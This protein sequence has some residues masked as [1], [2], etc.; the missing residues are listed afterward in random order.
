VLILRKDE[1]SASCGRGPGRRCLVP[2]GP[3]W[4]PWVPASLAHPT[5]AEKSRGSR[6]LHYSRLSCYVASHGLFVFGG[7][8]FGAG[9]WDLI[10][11]WRSAR[12]RSPRD[13]IDHSI[14]PVWGGQSCMAHLLPSSVLWTATSLEALCLDHTHTLR[15]N[16]DRRAGHRAARVEASRSARPST[17]T[18][19]QRNFGAAFANLL[20]HRALLLRCPLPAPIAS[21]T[22]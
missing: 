2:Y 18:R 16:R 9:F 10:A 4:G 13:E 21:W 12:C 5:E 3:R 22:A 20:G 8:D 6:E 19:D 15:P 7:A 1:S 11:R 14:G 17:A